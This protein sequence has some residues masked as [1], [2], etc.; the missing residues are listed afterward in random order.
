MKSGNHSAT[1]YSFGAASSMLA[2][3]GLDTQQNPTYSRLPESFTLFAV[4]WLFWFVLNFCTFS[5]THAAIKATFSR[6]V[7]KR[8]H[9]LPLLLG[10]L[11][12]P[13]FYTLAS[14]KKDVIIFPA[15]FLPAVIACIALVWLPKLKAKKLNQ[16][17]HSTR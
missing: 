10:L 16:V 6:A 5:A 14:L 15:A 3:W 17:E 4:G 11:F 8:I 7:K 12:G 9:V 1:W 2:M 13:A